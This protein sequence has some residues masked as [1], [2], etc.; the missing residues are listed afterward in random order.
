MFTDVPGTTDLV[1]HEIIVISAQPVRFKQY[2]VLYSLE[3]DIKSELDN[4][5]KL[6]PLI[7]RT[8]LL[9][10]WLENQTVRT[11]FVVTFAS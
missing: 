11:D 3:Q 7:Q 2:P 8:H 4:L 1:E 9:S 5:L 6:N 10:L